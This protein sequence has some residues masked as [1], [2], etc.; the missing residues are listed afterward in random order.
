MH[1]R[2]V[3]LELNVEDVAKAPTGQVESAGRVG[4]RH[5]KRLRCC[6][7]DRSPFV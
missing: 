5:G 2:T 3:F 6:T 7:V 1:W 4:A